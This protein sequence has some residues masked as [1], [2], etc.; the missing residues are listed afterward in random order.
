MCMPNMKIV[1]SCL[2]LHVYL[3]L[4]VDSSLKKKKLGHIN[5]HVDLNEMKTCRPMARSGR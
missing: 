5:I 1:S 3:D 4:H 2:C